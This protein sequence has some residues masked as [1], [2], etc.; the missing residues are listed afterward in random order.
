MTL[1]LTGARFIDPT[2]GDLQTGVVVVEEGP[3]GSVTVANAPPPGAAVIDCGGCLVTRSFAIAHHHIYSALARGMPPPATAPTTFV[4]VLQRI[5]WNLDRQLDADMIRASALISA[6]DAAKAGATFVID[7]HSS[8]NAAAGSL[9]IIAEELD[10]V[11]LGHLLCYELSDRDGDERL[12]AGLAET[13]SYLSS[14]QGL[15]GLHASFTVSPSLLERAVELARK[16]GTGLHVHVA[17]ATSDQEHCQQTYGCRVVERFHDAGVLASPGTL[18]AHCL[19]LDDRERELLADGEAWVVQNS[20]SNQNNNVGRLDV[21]G[22]GDRILIGTDGM[23][24]D[25]LASARAAYLEADSMS[26]LD[27]YR[28]LRRVHDYLAT[29]NARGDGANNLVVLR[30]D[31]P[32]PVTPENWP[33]HVVYGL[34]RG[35]VEH[36]ISAGRLIVERGRVTTV[37]EAEVRALGA[38]QAQR[39]WEKL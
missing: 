28:R 17:E 19:H 32:T 21:R 30:Y 37:D 27:A 7:H 38:A 8:P 12:D 11:G 3:G 29:N 2:S 25:V 26:P 6:V 9:H 34:H 18:L 33:A 5:W 20:E 35:H 39:L 31:E 13:D 22:L 24:G 10:R 15:V 1:A 23:H 4:E 16:H 36:V 14:H